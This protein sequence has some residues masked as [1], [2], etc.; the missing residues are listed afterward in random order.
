MHVC[1]TIY[2]HAHHIVTYIPILFSTVDCEWRYGDFGACSETC[3]EGIRERF[4]IV[5]Q[6]PEH[7]GEP[8]PPF[9]DANRPDQETCNLGPCESKSIILLTGGFTCYFKYYHIFYI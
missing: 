9:V 8:C 5:T 1:I 2:A 7:G 4:P 6:H 3:G